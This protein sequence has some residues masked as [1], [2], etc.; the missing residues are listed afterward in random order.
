MSKRRKITTTVTV[1]ETV[2]CGHKGCTRGV[3]RDRE[4]GKFPKL[5]LDHETMELQKRMYCTDP[6]C[7]GW[8][9]GECDPDACGF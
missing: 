8:D 3:E 2:P 9:H 4:T 1:Y 5:C 6:Q 7:Q